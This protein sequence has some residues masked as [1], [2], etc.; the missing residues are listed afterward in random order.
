MDSCAN[1]DPAAAWRFFF[2]DVEPRA[3]APTFL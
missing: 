3:S 1:R 2:G